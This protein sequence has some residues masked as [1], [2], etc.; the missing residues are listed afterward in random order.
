M[1]DFQVDHNS[2]LTYSDGSKSLAAKFG[3]LAELLEQARV[4]DE[5]FG[6]IGDAVGL[7]SGYFDSL[8]ECQTMAAKAAEFLEHV[9]E[10]VAETAR[11]YQAVDLAFQQA[12]KGL[13]G[14]A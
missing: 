3:Q 5:C 10:Q 14:G 6:P 13:E 1:S 8:Q 7:S 12:F 4:D 2:L 11:D 9:G